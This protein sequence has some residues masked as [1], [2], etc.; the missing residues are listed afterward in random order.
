M[1]HLARES[2][3]LSP[4][5]RSLSR[6]VARARTL[7]NCS[8]CGIQR[9]TSFLFDLGFKKKKKSQILSVTVETGW[10]TQMSFHI[11]KNNSHLHKKK[12]KNSI[13]SWNKTRLLHIQTEMCPNPF[14]HS[15]Q[16]GVREAL[17]L[18]QESCQVSSSWG[19]Q[20]D[21]HRTCNRSAPRPRLTRKKGS[22]AR[23]DG[24]APPLTRDW[25]AFLTNQ[26]WHYRSL[27]P[28]PQDWFSEGAGQWW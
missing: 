16:L 3:D 26:T 25:G 12:K 18:A 28:K 5:W 27:A 21:V 6:S 1:N 22:N 11:S 7:Y 17:G 19:K 24:V 13:L 10:N 9:A 23:T 15:L 2:C 8:L 14:F 20:P 4:R